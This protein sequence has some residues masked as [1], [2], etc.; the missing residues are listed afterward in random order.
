MEGFPP[1]RRWRFGR[2]LSGNRRLSDQRATRRQVHS[3]GGIKSE[4]NQFNCRNC[5]SRT[6][7]QRGRHREF[8]I[9]PLPA[10][11]SA[12]HYSVWRA[13]AAKRAASSR[14]NEG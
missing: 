1:Y 8:R 6:E 3:R 10:G 11:F 12:S 5:R 14:S 13:G 2:Q 4:A 9:L 7:A